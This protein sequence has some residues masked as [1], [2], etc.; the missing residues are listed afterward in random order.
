MKINLLYQSKKQTILQSLETGIKD[1]V[2]N[3]KPFKMYV[4]DVYVEEA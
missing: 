4:V 2:V 1:R 3:V